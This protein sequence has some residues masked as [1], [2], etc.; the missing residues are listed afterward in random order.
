MFLNLKALLSLNASGFSLGMKRA[1]SQAKAFAK[2]IK[3]EFARAFGTAALIA[4]GAK[5][6]ES[7]DH[8][9]D[10]SAKL[11][12]STKTLQEW[13][14][15]A[16]KN[17]A[18]LQDVEQFFENLAVA[19]EK[20]LKG[21]DD[22]ITN[23]ERL[24]AS[25]ARLKS[26]GLGDIGESIWKRVFSV[27]N[28]QDVIAPLKAIS[29]GAGPELIPMFRE[30]MEEMKQSAHD[31]GAVLDDELLFTLKQIKSEAEQIADAF[32][33]P[34]ANAIGFVGNKLQYIMERFQVG[35]AGIAAFLYS[36]SLADPKK[37]LGSAAHT[38]GRGV[39]KGFG[40]NIPKGSGNFQSAMA[41]AMK[42]MEE[43][44][45]DMESSI[46]KRHAATKAKIALQK[47]LT[48]GSG[49]DVSP[50][51][52]AIQKISTPENL[53]NWQKAGAAVRQGPMVETVLK[54]IAEN[55]E[56]AAKRLEELKSLGEKNDP[57]DVEGYSD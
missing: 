57:K 31:A 55:T 47:A 14:Y 46:A 27:K 56:R 13:G 51:K 10:L 15:A 7:A 29:R 40:R 19:R 38:L 2:E 44:S 3:G 35:A 26:G 4:F 6:V 24:G 1:E 42:A 20:A 32:R 8:I 25:L 11:G 34:V 49:S 23:L 21:D 37:T 53:T 5:I 54:T 22:S 30:N 43:A 12:I 48:N 28:V 18:N 45:S 50:E 16:K 9:V 41:D 33:G 39:L 36:L 52:T 17:G